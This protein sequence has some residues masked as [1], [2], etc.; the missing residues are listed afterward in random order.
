MAK[1]L[2]IETEE[3]KLL[4]KEKEAKEIAKWEKEKAK[5]KLKGYMAYFCL[6]ITI[7]YIVDEVTTQIGGQMEDAITSI[8]STLFGAEKA[9]SSIKLVGTIT[10]ISSVLALLYKP[11][12]DKFGRR[13]FLIINTFGM[14]LGLLIT[15]LTTALP[16]YVIGSLIIA[17]FT[18][19]DM[20]VI[21]IQ[22]CCPKD[23]RG[24]YYTII[25]SIATLGMLVI[26]VFR[27]IF[28][29]NNDYTQWRFV[30][31]LPAII[32]GIISIIAILCM[33]ET[34]PFIDN[35][36]N[37]LRMSDEER[38]NAKKEKAAVAQENGFIGGFKYIFKH[39][40]ILWLCLANPLIWMGMGIS[41]NYNV[42]MKY[43]Y[44]GL[45]TAEQVQTIIS[46]GGEE[47]LTAV[48]DAQSGVITK[49]LYTFAVGSAIAQ[50]IPGFI[51]DKWGRKKAGV[52]SCILS[53]I[54]FVLFW[55]G[56]YNAWSPYLTGL[57]GGMAVGSFWL[58]GD[59]TQFIC[60]EMVP[61]SVRV[62][63]NNAFGLFFYPGVAIGM[64]G[65]MIVG[66]IATDVYLPIATLITS[67]VGMTI[68]CIILML[69]V[70]ETKGT[71]MEEVTGNE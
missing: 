8:F 10:I 36:I 37:Y 50:L 4:R 26:P 21:Y 41:Q 67:V 16:I 48:L 61:T 43:G 17:F 13:L 54:T 55:L 23:K 2:K 25:K 3:H 60:S 34:D 14:G 57:F 15:G 33:R 59:M 51:A 44:A 28:I 32:A 47:A 64:F 1:T 46:A 22:E 6:I 49:A 27:D 12:S 58:A 68:G 24:T 7:V 42:I 69:K 31:I 65:P 40:S 19:H 71:D 35:R 38:E 29:P 45:R 39:K 66:M 20:Q 52:F 62:S 56:A 9:T 63:V 5:P 70:R 18:P 53:V 30:Y 11:L